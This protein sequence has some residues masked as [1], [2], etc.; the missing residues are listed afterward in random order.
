[1]MGMNISL[2]VK[3][4]KR[5]RLAPS[6]WTRIPRNIKGFSHRRSY[7]KSAYNGVQ[8]KGESPK[9]SWG[10][11]RHADA[12]EIHEILH[13][14]LM[15]NPS[16]PSTKKSPTFSRQEAGWESFTKVHFPLLF[17]SGSDRWRKGC[18]SGQSQ[19]PGSRAEPQP[20]NI[21]CP[22]S[23]GMW[24]HLPRGILVTCGAVIAK[25]RP[26]FPLQT[27]LLE[28]PWLCFTTVHRECR[29][30]WLVIYFKGL[31]VKRSHI[32]TWWRSDRIPVSEPDPVIECDLH[33]SW[34]DMTTPACPELWVMV[35]WTVVACKMVPIL[36]PS[37]YLGLCPVTLWWPPTVGEPSP[38]T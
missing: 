13:M 2:F 23:V 34:E 21:S 22:Q 38:T 19:E 24:G 37:S 3:I 1:M 8:R 12:Q 27:G 31:W 18:C 15:A 5:I 4:S 28:L 11:F 9:E 14:A 33:G 25:C 32:Q 17:G 7:A 35:E 6:R 36:Y 26:F 16:P 10:G 30:R 20:G 29:N